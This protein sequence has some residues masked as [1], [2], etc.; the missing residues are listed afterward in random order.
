MTPMKP[1]LYVEA[2][3]R[4][5]IGFGLTAPDRKG[6]MVDLFL[7]KSEMAEIAERYDKLKREHKI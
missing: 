2:L 6:K 5:I 4:R 7:T 3:E 1:N